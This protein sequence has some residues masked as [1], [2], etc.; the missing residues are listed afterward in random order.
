MI[1]DER[2]TIEEAAKYLTVNPRT[3]RDAINRGEVPAARIGRRIILSKAVLRA[4]LEGKAD[5]DSSEEF[6]YPVPPD[7]MQ[8]A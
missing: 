4:M 7:P 8:A 2:M 3:L 5:A 1:Y 6:F